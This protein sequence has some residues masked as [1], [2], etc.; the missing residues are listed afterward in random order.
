MWKRE[1]D[2]CSVPA[3]AV[4][5]LEGTRG[6][7]AAPADQA[8]P[9]V[10]AFVYNPEG[11]RDPFV[12]LFQR[13]AELAESVAAG[14]TG[15]AALTVEEVALRGVLQ[16]PQGYVALVEG[17][18]ARTYIVRSGDQLRDGTVERIASEDMV[19]RQQIN[20]PLS[21]ETEREVR[22]TLRQT[23]EAVP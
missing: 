10:A 11:R 8:A 1:Y 16:T 22:K 7:A 4:G 20:D 14:A 19:I 3:G 23:E 13:G 17:A 5:F 18:D 21:A 9:S 12:S 15:V 6:G 2:G